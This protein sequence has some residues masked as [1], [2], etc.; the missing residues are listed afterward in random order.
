MIEAAFLCLIAA[1]MAL[2]A[3][4]LL[5]GTSVQWRVA[6]TRKTPWPSPGAAHPPDF[7]GAPKPLAN[8]TAG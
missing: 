6:R 5:I 1:S 7:G 3:V 2:I 8:L 4:L